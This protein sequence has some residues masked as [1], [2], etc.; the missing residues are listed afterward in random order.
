MEA[1]IPF[2]LLDGFGLYLSGQDITTDEAFQ[3][4]LEFF[5]NLF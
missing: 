1:P 5:I 2:K 4:A 3:Y